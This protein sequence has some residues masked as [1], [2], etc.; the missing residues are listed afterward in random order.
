MSTL[1]E[2]VDAGLLWQ[3]AKSSKKQPPN[4]RVARFHLDPIDERL[5]DNGLPFGH[6]HEWA[7]E[8]AG[9][10]KQRYKN[11]QWFAPLFL[12]SALLGKAVS[13]G[14]A[15]SGNEI[16]EHSVSENHTSSEHRLS[17]HYSQAQKFLLVWIGKKCWPTPQLLERVLGEYGWQTRS[18]FLNPPCR[19]TRAW[20]I[21]ETLRNPAVLA[22]V[23]DGSGFDTSMM[24]RMQLAAKRG[25]SLGFIVRPPWEQEVPST[26]YSRWSVSPKQPHTTQSKPNKFE[27]TE[28]A[29]STA[30]PTAQKSTLGDSTVGWQLTLRKI[31][32]TL[33]CPITWNIEWGE[34]RSHGKGALC[35]VQT[36]SNAISRKTRI[37][38]AA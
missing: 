20:S 3:M 5:P 8:T 36:T 10:K 26:A 16:Y 25:N 30:N 4:Q 19:E 38:S 37:S 31:R 23:A 14:N 6:V 34:E 28:T 7:L 22:V 32:G 21:S 13:T 1:E 33:Q 2:L 18:I 9:S 29:N 24:R 35:H 12:L 27:F 11:G 15:V 17:T